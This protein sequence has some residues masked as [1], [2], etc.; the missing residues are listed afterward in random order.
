M[1]IKLPQLIADFVQAK[2]CAIDEDCVGLPYLFFPDFVA[3][4][5]QAEKHWE[6]SMKALERFTIKSSAEFAVRPF[7][8]RDPERMMLQMEASKRYE[9]G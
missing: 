1:P 5:G 6:L 2:K 3:V 9:L 7:L 8:L 4:Y